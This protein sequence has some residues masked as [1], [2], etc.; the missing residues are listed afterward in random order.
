[1]HDDAGATI[2]SLRAAL[3]AAEARA[4]RAEE[5]A[6]ALADDLTRARQRLDGFL[7]NMPGI[8][9]ENYF[10]PDPVRGR[11]LYVNGNVQTL[12]GYSVEEWIQPNFWF[13]I[14]HPEDREIASESTRRVLAEGHGTTL[15]RFVTKDGRAVWVTARMTVIRDDAGAPIGLRGVTLDIT[16]LKEAE[17]E[18]NQA[19]LREQ[20]LRAQ[21]ESLLALSTP[22][23]PIGDDLLAMTLVGG[24]DER[25][26][27]RVL[28]TLLEGVSRHGARVVILDVTG[29]PDVDD[30]TADAL[31]RAARA[32][33]L[34]GAE[35]VLTG[36]R[37]EVARTLVEIGS[38]LGSI[39]TR[40]TLKAG[41]GYA[42][43]RGAG[44][45]RMQR[46]PRQILSEENKH[47]QDP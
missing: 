15:Y 30:R 22:L 33:S 5:R 18:R 27:D 36:I 28:E 16:D 45:L 39:I 34:L 8:V 2:E 46:G 3:A 42:M 31:L 12:L 14:V 11:A 21:Q 9:W 32:V 13:E 40:S 1:M 7:A 4:A 29:V 37:P 24:L 19:M 23:V 25:R 41:I 20:V 26:A 38:D 10:D 35:V 17:E 44:G 43:Q 6:A 47:D